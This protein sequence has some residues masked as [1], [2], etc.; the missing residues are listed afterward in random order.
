[1]STLQHTLQPAFRNRLALMVVL[2]AA[3]AAVTVTLIITAGG[4]SSIVQRTSP[5]GPESQRAQRQLDSV[6][7]ARYGLKPPA[8][9]SGSGRVKP[10][11]QLQAVNGARYGQPV[12]IHASH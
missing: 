9:T 12:G 8:A 11:D 3:L 4:S 7:G 6:N 2:A 1:M 10:A 5:S